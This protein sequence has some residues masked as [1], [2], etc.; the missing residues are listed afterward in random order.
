MEWDTTTTDVSTLNADGGATR[1]VSDVNANGSLR[2]KTVTTVSGDR[3]LTMIAR[4]VDGNGANDQTEAVQIQADGATVDTVSNLQTDGSVKSKR[5]ST[6]SG[7]GLSSQTDFSEL[8]THYNFVWVGYWLPVPYQSLDVI[9]AVTDVITLNADGGRVDTFTQY[10]GPVS[11]TISERIVTTTSDDGLSVSKQ[12]TAS[13][14]AAAINQT[15][16]DVTT[17]NADGSTTRVVTDQLPG[18][19]SG[20]GSGGSGLLDKAVI[21][22]S[23]STLKTTYQ[24]DVNGDGTF[25]R[26]GIS[27]VGVDGAS[28]GTITIKN[29][30]G[31]LRQ[32]EAA[33]TSLDGLRQNLTRDSNGDGAYDHFESGRQE[34][35][36]AT[37]RV[38]WETKSSGALGDRIVTLASANGLATT[39]ALD[40]NGDGVVDWSQLSVEK[41]NANGSRTTTLS[42]LNANGTLRDRIVTTFSANG[43]SKTSQINLNGLGN[44]IETETDVTTLNADGSLTRTVTDLYADS[45]LKGKSVFTASANGKSATTTIDIDGDAVTDKTISVNEDAD[46]IKVSTVTFK[47]GAT[48][49]T[50]TSFDGLTTTMTTSAGVTQRRA[51][52]GD[53]T[54]SYSWNSTD[55]HGNSLASSS[56]TIDENKIDAYVYSSQNSSGTIRIETDALQQYLSKAERLYDAAFDRDMFVDERELIGKYINSSTNAFDANQLANDLMNATEFSTRYGALSNLQFVERVYANA[57]GRAA[58][59][60]EAASYVK[61]LNAGTLTRADLLN[62]ISENAE[63]IADGN[64]HAATNNSVQSAASF[65]LDHTVDKQQA[66]DMVTRLYQTA[67]GRD[68]TATE[69]SNGYQ[70]IVEGSGTEAG[71]ANNIVSPQWVWWPYIANPSQFDQTYGSLSNADFVTRL[72]LNSMGRNPTAAESSDWTAMLDNGAVTRGDMIYAL[73][74]SLEH[75]AYMGSQAGQAVTASN[76]TLNY[77]ENAIV[78]INGGGNTINA[79]SGDILTIGGNGAGGVNNIVNISNG[80]ASLLSNSRMDVLGSRN[81]VT[82]GLGSALGVNGDDNVLSA[83]GDGVWINGGSGNIVSGSGNT[84]AVAAN[85]SVDVVDD[86]NSINA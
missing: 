34:A 57:L 73:A 81:V 10:M 51:E 65:A 23:A 54:G 7:D 33:A 31:S 77:G 80:S 86:G 55:S 60:S 14:G 9:K 38:V 42:D 36:G 41:I 45:S 35:S 70:A 40:T 20:V 71:L 64:A 59:A 52:L 37:S 83:N 85:L 24:L 67:L 66:E 39:E 43:L 49:T 46:G 5:M 30:D 2:D 25:D 21:D 79:S 16:S 8:T 69:L 27:T 19:G 18:G 1:T 61:Q 68:P 6:V 56:H 75:L 58:S 47:D 4:D 76:Q 48:A 78:R 13:N 84:I 50:T 72:Y 26:T 82:S 44:A 22:V 29:L 11:G 12:W 17:Y 74:E 3:R 32:K 53:G 15:S 62:A 28:A 63:H